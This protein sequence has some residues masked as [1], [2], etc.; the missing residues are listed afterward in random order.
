MAIAVALKKIKSEPLTAD[1]EL[2]N[3]SVMG[4]TGSVAVSD[5]NNCQRKYFALKS[6]K[7]TTWVEVAVVGIIEI[8]SAVEKFDD[9]LPGL[10]A[11][12]FK[13]SS[14]YKSNSFL[15]TPARFSFSVK[16]L[17][18]F[19]RRRTSFELWISV[20]LVSNLYSKISFQGSP[21]ENLVLL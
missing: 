2:L 20:L 5:L 14:V 21:Y 4:A 8:L 13:P 11:E 17:A 10:I 9:L 19:E 3:I 12:D 18:S 7:V 15:V 16:S 6:G 1:E